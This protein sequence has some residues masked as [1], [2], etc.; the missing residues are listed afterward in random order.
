VTNSRCVVF[1]NSEK[2]QKQGTARFQI[3]TTEK[4]LFKLAA[5][6]LNPFLNQTQ[7]KALTPQLIALLF[8]LLKK[9]STQKLRLLLNNK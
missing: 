1:T 3:C 8:P 7:P 6:K 9:Y 5:E 4:Q 2:L